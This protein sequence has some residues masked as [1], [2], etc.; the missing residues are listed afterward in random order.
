MFRAKWILSWVVKYK[1]FSLSPS[2]LFFF[3][4]LFCSFWLSQQIDLFGN[5]SQNIADTQKETTNSHLQ[6]EKVLSRSYFHTEFTSQF[7]LQE[8]FTSSSFAL[9]FND[10]A[11]SGKNQRLGSRWVLSI[12]FFIKDFI[13]ALVSHHMS[14]FKFLFS[15][16]FIL[17]F[18]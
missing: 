9:E 14:I 12:I 13:S 8:V 16:G 4:G 5:F 15:L 6:V 10:M 18:S 1:C 11:N 3:S 17:V 7:Y 2:S